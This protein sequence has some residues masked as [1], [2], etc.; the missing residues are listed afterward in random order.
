[1]LAIGESARLLREQ[2]G[3]SQK[4]A[5]TKLGI[6]NVHLCN[7]ENCRSQPSQE[8]LAKYH[9]VLGVD[10]YVFAWCQHEDV[11]RLPKSL[12]SAARS[13]AEGWK[14]QIDS[15]VRKQQRLQD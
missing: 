3:L 9:E 1:M 2:F 15:Q 14:Q 6:S 8:L 5:A 7:V 12:R 4:E 11:D 10:L 13:L